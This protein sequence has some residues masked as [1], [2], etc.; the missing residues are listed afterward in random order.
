MVRSSSDV[1]TGTYNTRIY[2]GSYKT[3]SKRRWVV[4]VNFELSLWSRWG[5]DSVV[6]FSVLSYVWTTRLPCLAASKQLLGVD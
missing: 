1:H 6:T 3:L 2:R 4:D 5:W